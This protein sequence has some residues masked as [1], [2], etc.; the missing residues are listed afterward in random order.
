MTAEL[1]RWGRELA[2]LE[3]NH[4]RMDVAELKARR[5]AAL[6]ATTDLTNHLAEAEPF[7]G[8]MFNRAYELALAFDRVGY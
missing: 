6:R 7:D 4:Q 2:H 3:A 1:D 5:G 8:V